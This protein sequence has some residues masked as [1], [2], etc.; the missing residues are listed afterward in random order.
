MESH[1]AAGAPALSRFCPAFQATAELIGR[2]WTAAIIRNLLAGSVRFSDILAQVP[3]LSD[4]LLTERLRELES[5]GIVLRT[6]IPESPVRVEY[7]LTQKGHELRH[8]VEALDTWADRWA[9][10]V[11]QASSTCIAAMALAE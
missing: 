3:G 5:E 10:Q 8:I 4:R 6:V 9:A 1:R 11:A 2:R 7:S